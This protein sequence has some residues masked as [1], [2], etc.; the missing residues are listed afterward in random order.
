MLL[1][2][3]KPQISSS[4]QKGGRAGDGRTGTP[5]GLEREPIH[6]AS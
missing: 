5:G 3:A 6:L 1:K 2:S 4:L